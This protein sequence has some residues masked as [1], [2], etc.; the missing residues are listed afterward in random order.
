MLVIYIILSV[1]TA[2]N[3]V[4][5]REDK[6][7]SIKKINIYLVIKLFLNL[8]FANVYIFLSNSIFA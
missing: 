1:L 5:E 7:K 2:L 6:E 4:K 3:L 8:I